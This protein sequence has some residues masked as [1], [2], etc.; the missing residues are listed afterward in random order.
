M[1]ISYFTPANDPFVTTQ[2]IKEIVDKY[3]NKKEDCNIYLCPV[4]TKAQV[5]GFTLF[6]ITED[7]DNLGIIFPYSESFQLKL[8]KE[9]IELGYILLNSKKALKTLFQ[10]V[11]F[12]KQF[13]RNDQIRSYPQMYLHIQFAYK[14]GE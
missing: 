8:A 1:M 5:L 14:K 13:K 12:T 3:G 6:F 7:M 9:E 4:S 10:K 11:S 2:T